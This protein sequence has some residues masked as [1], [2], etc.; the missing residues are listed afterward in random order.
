MSVTG[1]YTEDEPNLGYHAF[2]STIHYTVCIVMYTFNKYLTWNVFLRNPINL[3]EVV[4]ELYL[5]IWHY[6]Y[7]YYTLY[8]FE[9]WNFKI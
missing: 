5:N 2:F 3:I 7:R 1:F 9:I 4:I 6:F 8:V